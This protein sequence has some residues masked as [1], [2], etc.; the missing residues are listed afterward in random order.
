MKKALS[1]ILVFF[2]IG[3]GPVP[4]PLREDDAYVI[5]DMRR[6]FVRQ[7]AKRA[8]LKFDPDFEDISFVPGENAKDFFIYVAFMV[9]IIGV[10]AGIER[11]IK[12]LKGTDIHVYPVYYPEYKQRVKWGKN[13]VFIPRSLINRSFKLHVE[14]SG[15][16][17]GD[18][19][20]HINPESI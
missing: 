4:R 9:V 10:S 17:T 1:C 13:K 2:L 11:S 19:I 15:S 18:G 6:K 5:I 16:F 12:N 20:I 8:S 14:I 7:H 3:C